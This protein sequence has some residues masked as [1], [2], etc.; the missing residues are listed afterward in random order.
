MVRLVIA[1]SFAGGVRIAVGVKC[2]TAVMSLLG[3]LPFHS[4]RRRFQDRAMI[5][6]GATS[7]PGV[8]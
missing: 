5:V 2:T 6:M 8:N 1:G 7:E 3:F 4:G